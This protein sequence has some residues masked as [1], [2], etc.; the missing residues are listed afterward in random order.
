MTAVGLGCSGILPQPAGH[1]CAQHARAR[2][3]TLQALPC[4]HSRQGRVASRAPSR[5]R[6]TIDR[7]TSSTAHHRRWRVATVSCGARTLSATSRASTARRA[8]AAR[9]LFS[10]SASPASVSWGACCPLAHRFWIS[11]RAVRST[12]ACVRTWSAPASRRSLRLR[13]RI[14]NGGCLVCWPRAR[15]KSTIMPTRSGRWLAAVVTRIAAARHL[16]FQIAHMMALLLMG[17]EA[18]SSACAE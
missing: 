10:Y 16:A 12:S 3:C 8:R 1:C 13:L 14:S 4:R 15:R 9:S 18:A 2:R 11:A 5:R 17:W 7:R 6:Q